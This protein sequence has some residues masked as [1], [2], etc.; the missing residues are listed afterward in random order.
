AGGVGRR[1]QD[2][3]AIRADHGRRGR[4]RE[5]A[6]GAP[7]RDR[8]AAGMRPLELDS[9]GGP[10]ADLTI[11]YAHVFD[12]REGLDA[13]ADILVRG[14]EIASIGPGLD[15]PEGVEM[16]DAEG[17][18]AFPAFVDPHVHLRTPG[19]EDEEDIETGSRAAAAG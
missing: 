16:L 11:R 7:P 3:G 19:R 9:R 8:A 13:I 18:H 15:A 14:G 1:R 12:P 17:L 5:R 6:V 4:S 2:G 10:G